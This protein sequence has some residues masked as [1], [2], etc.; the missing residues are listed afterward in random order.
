MALAYQQTIPA[1]NFRI[2]AGGGR[3]YDTND[4]SRATLLAGKTY[5]YQCRFSMPRVPTTVAAGAAPS[6]TAVAM[7]YRLEDIGGGT[8]GSVTSMIPSLTR[9]I[10]EDNGIEQANAISITTPASGVSEGYD[11]DA[12]TVVNRARSTIDSPQ[13]DNESSIDSVNYV[14]SITITVGSTDMVLRIYGLEIF[15]RQD[16]A[17]GASVT[18]TTISS[19]TTPSAD[20]SGML[21][22]V[23]TTGGAVIITLPAVGSANTGPGM[24]FRFKIVASTNQLNIDPNAADNIRGLNLNAAGSDDKDF[25]LATPAVGDYIYLVS[26]GVNGW[27]VTSASGTWTREA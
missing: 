2:V 12:G 20:K 27:Y 16:L 4:N 22:P 14:F 7:S 25:I 24:T 6:L 1:F 10:Y 13:Y 19:S 15:Y 26:D 23:D 21:I 5:V 11:L 17:S 18:D 8:T 3:D 9:L